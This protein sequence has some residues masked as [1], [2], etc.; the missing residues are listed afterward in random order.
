M[1]TLIE[2][3]EVHGGEMIYLTWQHLY[4]TLSALFLGTI[5]A[6]P[7]GILLN[8]VPRKFGQFIIGI[9]SIMQTFPSLAILAFVIPFLGIGQGPAIFALFIYSLLPILR[10]TYVGIRGVDPA[11]N[12]SGKG[13]G[14]SAWE[15][16][17]HVELPLATPVIMSGIRLAS[18]Y[19]VGWA[20]LASY[21]GGGGL[22]DFIFNGLNLYQPEFIFAGA[23]PVTLMAL[24][25]ELTLSKME[26]GMTPNGLKA[27]A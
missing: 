8:K 25:F 14:M 15:R 13:M 7:L 21:I 22:G 16:V 1:N 24:L 6:V 11:L 17:R 2:F 27:A 9:V 19:L 20:T 26:K 4:I 18:V 23:I 3:L 5:V 10:N 12:E